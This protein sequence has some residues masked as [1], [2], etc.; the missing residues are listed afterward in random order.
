MKSLCV[1]PY[2]QKGYIIVQIMTSDPDEET[3]ARA[4]VIRML[5]RAPDR[6]GYPASPANRLAWARA[7]ELERR[8]MLKD[9][10]W[11]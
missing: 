9:C 10:G 6:K 8:R 4:Y 2:E 3:A 7:T 1:L 11:L 5:A